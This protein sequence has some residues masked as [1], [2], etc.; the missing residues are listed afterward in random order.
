MLITAVT[1]TLV[2]SLRIVSNETQCEIFTTQF[3]QTQA[4]INVYLIQ[5]GKG[6]L[7]KIH[8]FR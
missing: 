1:E 3:I 2:L 6:I 7:T 4:H 5:W 8:A